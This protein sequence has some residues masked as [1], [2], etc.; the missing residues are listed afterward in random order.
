MSTKTAVLVCD[1]L[2]LGLFDRVTIWLTTVGLL[3]FG[4]SL[5]AAAVF[6]PGKTL[7]AT[8][9]LLAFGVILLTT[10]L[11]FGAVLRARRDRHLLI[12]FERQSVTFEN[13]IFARPM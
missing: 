8:S 4:A 13:F 1:E 5:L 2:P 6:L 9:L 10:G 7:V 12:D 3:T 11:A